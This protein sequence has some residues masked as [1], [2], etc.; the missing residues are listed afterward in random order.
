M[1]DDVAKRVAALRQRSAALDA[2][3][4]AFI[5]P[6]APVVDVSQPI[7]HRRIDLAVLKPQDSWQL[8]TARQLAGLEA[9]LHFLRRMLPADD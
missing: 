6:A 9:H 1:T 8:A 2:Q 7:L 5:G 4:A 3:L